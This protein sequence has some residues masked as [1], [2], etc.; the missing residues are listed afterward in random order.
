MVPERLAPA[1]RE[2]EP[3]E[4]RTVRGEPL[5]LP[6][7]APDCWIAGVAPHGI[8]PSFRGRDRIPAPGALDSIFSRI[9]RITATIFSWCSGV[10]RATG[11][12]QLI[13]SWA[14]AS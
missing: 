3:A 12:E 4:T 9:S 5:T 11:T 14:G 7:V 8:R 6:S 1:V 2:T 10:S 13:A